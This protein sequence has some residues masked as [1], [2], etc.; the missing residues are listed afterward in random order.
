[1]RLTQSHCTGQVSHPFRTLSQITACLVLIATL[2]AAPGCEKQEPASEET[3]STATPPAGAES[4]A[5]EVTPS[6]EPTRQPSAEPTSTPVSSATPKPPAKTE[7]PKPTP[8]SAQAPSSSAQSPVTQVTAADNERIAKLS[9]EKGLPEPPDVAALPPDIGAQVIRMV[10]KAAS[11]GTAE[12]VGRLGCLY[13]DIM[14]SRDDTERAVACFER[15][16]ELDPK[17]YIWSHMLGRVFLRRASY[18]RAR[19]EFDKS[20]E[21]NPAYPDNY[22]WAADL[23]FRTDDMDGAIKHYTKFIELAPNEPTGYA[24]IAAAELRKDEADKAYEHLQKG[25][26]IDPEDRRIHAT[27]AQYYHKI[28]NETR[29]AR[30]AGFAN[31]LR[32]SRV[33]QDDPINNELLLAAGPTTIAITQLQTLAAGGAIEVADKLRDELLADY[34]DNALLLTGCAEVSLMAGRVEEGTDFARKALK[35]DPDFVRALVVLSDCELAGGNPEEAIKTT[36]RAI[37]LTEGSPAAFVAKARALRL[38]DRR[39][40]ALAEYRKALELE[41]NNVPLKIAIGEILRGMDR[42]D[43]AKEWCLNLVRGAEA[44]GKVTPDLAPAY[45]TLASIAH[46]QDDAQNAVE[47]LKRAVLTDPTREPIFRQLAALLIEL[48]QGDQAVELAK[49]MMTG[50][51]HILEYAITYGNLLAATGKTD[52]A[53]KHLQQLCEEL[54]HH[55]APHLALANILL[56]EN[57]LDEANAHLDSILKTQD[58]N[59]SAYLLKVDIARRRNDHKSAIDAAEIGHQKVPNSTLIENSLAWMLATSPN[60]ELRNPKRAVELSEDLVERTSRRMPNYI[61]TLAC[62]YAAAG[63][64]DDAVKSEKEAMEVAQKNEMTD[65]A[66]ESEGRIKLFE[67]KQAFYEKE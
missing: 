13:F 3:A 16:R 42:L 65:L 46:E 58:T 7:R 51:P 24:G 48:G 2:L 45:L 26:E 67:Q 43:E 47:S 60:A 41:P 17:S 6:A 19:I 20:I 32:P 11:T 22:A 36:D 12:S 35:V 9:E 8:A 57:K 29:A 18:V 14:Q 27:L 37:A 39:E 63:R 52:E 34:P 33:T 40:E 66:A 59:E 62:A 50:Q 56:N 64:F 28:G 15:A 30:H 21:L 1:M 55:P 31:N 4:T 25:L 5:K 44:D 10:D 61:D 38:L 23:A 54:P 49:R 53:I